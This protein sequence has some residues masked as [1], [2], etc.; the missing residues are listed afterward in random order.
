MACAAHVTAGR[1]PSRSFDVA[2]S[3]GRVER[4]LLALFPPVALGAVAAADINTTKPAMH[5]TV[6]EIWEIDQLT[7]V[8]IGHIVP[9]GPLDVSQS[10]DRVTQLNLPIWAHNVTLHS[11]TTVKAVGMMPDWAS[12]L[13][14]IQ[15]GIASAIDV[16]LT[17]QVCTLQDPTVNPRGGCNITLAPT[18]NHNRYLDL[19]M[20]FGAVAAI[21]PA[22][23][24]R[25]IVAEDA[26]K[27]VNVPLSFNVCVSSLRVDG[28][29]IS[30][31]FI[32]QN[33]APQ[34]AASALD[35]A[36]LNW[37]NGSLIDAVVATTADFPWTKCSN[38]SAE[39]TKP[40]Y[41]DAITSALTRLLSP[42]FSLSFQ[43]QTVTAHSGI[44]F[45]VSFSACGHL[46]EVP[47]TIQSHSAA[48]RALLSH[49]GHKMMK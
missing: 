19:R 9:T 28:V 42:G 45:Q 35:A 25:V 24:V 18:E 27:A 34:P 3:M 13:D 8:N 14:E 40:D 38:R 37:A 12:H 20:S 22:L 44:A 39:S 15:S 6:A 31:R 7:P 1:V 48:V 47:A 49:S 21:G 33:M 4:L 30:N 43:T 41:V 2:N 16:D 32:G 29:A 36:R 23:H 46:M 26:S 10:F 5:M 11:L 17:V